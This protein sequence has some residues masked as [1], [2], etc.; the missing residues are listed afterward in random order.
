[1]HQKGALGNATM[2]SGV[3]DRSQQSILMQFGLPP[4]DKRVA[5]VWTVYRKRERKFGRLSQIFTLQGHFKLSFLHLQ[6]HL[7]YHFTSHLD[8]IQTPLLEKVCIALLSTYKDFLEF[9][10]LSLPLSK[11][12]ELALGGGHFALMLF[13]AL[14]CYPWE[15]EGTRSLCQLP[16]QI[17]N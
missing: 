2:V 11:I 4:G 15:G 9:L 1:M 13:T 5:L 6:A 3:S 10:S 8:T 17:A 14:I 12:F 16:S 7:N